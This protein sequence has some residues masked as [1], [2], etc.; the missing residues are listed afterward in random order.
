MRACEGRKT[1]EGKGLDACLVLARELDVL[2]VG[3]VNGGGVRAVGDVLR[4]GALDH[5]GSVVA[6]VGDEEDGFALRVVANDEAV[7]CGEPGGRER[8][9]GAALGHFRRACGWRWRGELR[10]EVGWEEE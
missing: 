9:D 2:V 8:G 7:L 6:F 5:D 1:G 10:V 3:Q 4:R